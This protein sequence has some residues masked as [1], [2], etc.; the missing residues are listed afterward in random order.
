MKYYLLLGSNIGNSKSY[1]EKAKFMLSQFV[2]ED[3]EE[4][5]IY[6]TEPW[7]EKDQ[8]YFLNQVIVIDSDIEPNDVMNTIE[9]I[10]KLLGKR[11]ETRYGP[12]TID[13]DVL[14]C[15]DQIID[16]KNLIVPHP[17][18]HKRAFTLI[19]LAEISDSILHPKLDKTIAELLVECGDTSEVSKV[20]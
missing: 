9:R 8:S 2:G 4:S 15:D 16:N 1:I 17:R 20:Q 3:L 14:L 18:M 19:P 6:R 5:S 13:I 10:E 7:G 11:K 12:R